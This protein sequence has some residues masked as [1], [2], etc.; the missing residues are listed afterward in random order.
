MAT[1]ASATG[2]GELPSSQTSE[3]G[4][5]I[6]KH[7]AKTS[8][9][10][11]NCRCFLCALQAVLQEMADELLKGSV[12]ASSNDG[13]EDDKKARVFYGTLTARVSSFRRSRAQSNDC[14]S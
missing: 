7:K 13:Q 3:V 12:A 6:S 10:C 1:A 8:L 2:S 5:A 9:Q 11:C 4:L 14:A